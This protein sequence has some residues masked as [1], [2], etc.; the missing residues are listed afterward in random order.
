MKVLTVAE[1]IRAL[2]T[3]NNE[4]FTFQGVIKEKDFC[5]PLASRTNRNVNVLAYGTPGELIFVWLLW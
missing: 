5:K 4:L 1:A 3:T 2:K